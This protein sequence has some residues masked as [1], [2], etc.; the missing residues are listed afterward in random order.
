MTLAPADEEGGRQL[1][2][3]AAQETPQLGRHRGRMAPPEIDAG[4][5]PR[6]AQQP[7]GV[8]RDPEEEDGAG[9]GL[10]QEGPLQ[11]DSLST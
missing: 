6:G 1:A 9:E 3:E 8:D 2:V 4:R 7:A 10:E 5:R 11:R